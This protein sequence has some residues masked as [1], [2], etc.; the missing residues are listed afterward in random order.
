MKILVS[1]FIVLSF[2]IMMSSSNNL[3]ARPIQE[4]ALVQEAR[5]TID[6]PNHLS[7]MFITCGVG[8]MI[9]I[10]FKCVIEELSKIKS[11]F[12]KFTSLCEW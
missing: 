12:C 6:R 10:C 11:K 3:L 1:C 7:N 2:V 4:E 8:I 9:L 5:M